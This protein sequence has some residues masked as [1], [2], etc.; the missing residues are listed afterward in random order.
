MGVKRL[1]LNLIKKT[2]KKFPKKIKIIGIDIL[3]Y[4]YKYIYSASE[5]PLYNLFN[6]ISKFLIAGIIPLFVFD[7]KPIKEKKTELKERKNK[8]NLI[9]IKLQ[10]IK[11]NIKHNPDNEELH[12]KYN[13]LLKKYAT[14]DHIIINKCKK[15][16]NIMKVPY[17][18][19]KTEADFTCCRLYLDGIIQGCLTE[20][21]DFLLLGCQRN[22]H[23]SNGNIIEYN[24]EETLQTLEITFSQFQDFCLLL[25]CDYIKKYLIEDDNNTI[26]KKLKSK[27][28]I[29]KWIKNCEDKNLKDYLNK[30]LQLKLILN[31]TL[32]N[33]SL[34]IPTSNLLFNNEL[35]NKYELI[36]FFSTNIKNNSFKYHLTNTFDQMLEKINAY[37]YIL[38]I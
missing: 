20:D 24:L 5:E 13:K 18:T 7:G 11:K 17:I 36:K 4:I 31:K 30:C 10:E 34:T 21:M 14:I 12:I 32:F 27:K 23:F 6:M 15:L 22:F 33:E 28:S 9:K 19:A 2:H 1:K 3:L 25:G 38:N 35:I 26:L 16:M 29:R 8:R 37:K